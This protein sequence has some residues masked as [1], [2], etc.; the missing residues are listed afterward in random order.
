MAYFECF[1]NIEFTENTEYL[2]YNIE[3]FILIT[4]LSEGG[5]AQIYYFEGC[6]K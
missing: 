1:E 4:R 3:V 6:D 2:I 5:N